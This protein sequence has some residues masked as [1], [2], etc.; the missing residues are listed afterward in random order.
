MYQ[1]SRLG[2]IVKKNI[3]DILIKIFTISISIILILWSFYF[4]IC[5]RDMPCSFAFWFIFGTCIFLNIVTFFPKWIIGMK[6]TDMELKTALHYHS[7]L[8]NMVLGF[9]TVVG[10]GITLIWTTP[11]DIWKQNVYGR[12]A[13]LVLYF[14]LVIYFVFLRELIRQIAKEKN[15]K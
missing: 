11:G 6:I 1:L 10:I 9:S 12:L 14:I 3:E 7:T 4:F 2:Y 15:H 5:Q 8:T 13:I